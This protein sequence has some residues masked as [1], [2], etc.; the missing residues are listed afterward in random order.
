M[1][2]VVDQED[3]D[4][5]DDDTLRPRE[6]KWLTGNFLAEHIALEAWMNDQAA[7]G[8]SVGYTSYPGFL[9]WRRVAQ[10]VPAAWGSPQLYGII[11]PGTPAEIK[12]RGVAWKAAFRGG[13]VASLAAWDRTADEQA[14]YLSYFRDVPGAIFWHTRMPEPGTRLFDILRAFRPGGGGG[15]GLVGLVALALVGYAGWRA[16]RR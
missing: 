8:R 2:P 5:N 14:D 1:G 16:V 12:A 7:L 13:Y 15:G 10:N 3:I 9:Y 4:R 6:E 11:S